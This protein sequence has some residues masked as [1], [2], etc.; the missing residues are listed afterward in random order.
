[1]LQIQVGGV[2]GKGGGARRVMLRTLLLL[3]A[4]AAAGAITGCGGGSAPPTETA[5]PSEAAVVATATANA[6]ATPDPAVLLR[7]G[8]I[9]IIRAAYDRLLDEYIDPVAPSELLD[10]AWAGASAKAQGSGI[11]PPAAP[12]SADDREAAFGS[13][14][15]AY[16]QL[17][18]GLPDAK[19][20]RFAAIRSMAESLNDCH[21]FFLTP[22]ASDTL[23]DTRAGKGSVGIG[24]ELAGVPPLVTEVIPTGPADQA[25][26][27]VGDR[28]ASIDGADASA[29]GPAAAFD[30][31]NG[32]EGT[33]VRLQVRRSGQGTLVPLTLLRE[34]V[35]PPNVASR[36]VRP[37]IGY[38]RI[39][40]FT[41]TG[42][43]AD[44]RSAVSGFDAQGVMKWIIDLRDN[45]GGRLDVDA[46]SLFVKDGIVVRDRGR[47]DKT[48]DWRATG[49]VLS[50]VR[51]VVLLTDNRTGSVAEAFASALQEYGVAYV[52]GAKSNGC[53]GFTDIQDLGD[54]SSLA[55]TTDVNVGPVTQKPLNGTGVVPDEPVGRTSADIANGLDPQLQAAI[56]HFGG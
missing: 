32:D 30:L 14:A 37:A 1:M 41:D 28:I 42:V 54:G 12:V 13:F 17:V 33:Q 40:N 49:A 36:V 39:R 18:R 23:V 3:A 6:T 16:A 8:G 50:P 22:V 29:L 53:V 43:S 21:T 2:T 25:G 20:I 34:R 51:P 52:V 11:D 5:A 7:D 48:E 10:A 24:I 19:E 9:A 27:I 44:V 35:N 55:V 56:A 38:M 45:P 31:I 26:M 47:G 4:I 46:I 15:G